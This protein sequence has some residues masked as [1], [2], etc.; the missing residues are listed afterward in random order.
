MTSSL[1]SYPVVAEERPAETSTD[2][3][4]TTTEAPEKKVRKGYTI[5]KSRQSWTEGEHD[6]FLEALQLFDRDWKKNE[7]FVGSKTVIQ[8]PCPFLK[9]Q[10]NGTFAHVPPP[11]PKRNAAHPYPQKASKNGLFYYKIS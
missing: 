10:K 8:E 7:D 4:E 1:S 3:T 2:L 5:Y 11:T 6:K 9:V